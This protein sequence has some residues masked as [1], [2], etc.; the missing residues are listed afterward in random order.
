[1]LFN[2][3]R[4]AIPSTKTFV[5]G[6]QWQQHSFKIADFDKCDGTDVLGFWFGSHQTGEFQFRIDQ[7]KLVR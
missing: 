3:R 1:M 4:G 6:K 2:Q 7:V 5:A